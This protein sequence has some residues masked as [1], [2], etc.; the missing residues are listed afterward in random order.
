MSDYLNSEDSDNEETAH[1]KSELS[2]ADKEEVLKICA[3]LKA[4]GNSL[5]SKQDYDNALKSY[6]SAILKLKSVGLPQDSLLFLNRSATYLAV[7]RYVPALND[8]NIGTNQPCLFCPLIL[9]F[10]SHS[11]RDRS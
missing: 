3:E 5:Y 4:E 9:I 10:H 2:E 6:S 1:T 11:H 8:A 7:K